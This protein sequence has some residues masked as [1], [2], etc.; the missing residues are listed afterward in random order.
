MPISI[1]FSFVFFHAVVKSS[2]KFD[3]I[4]LG[5]AKY[6]IYRGQKTQYFILYRDK[7]VSWG[8]LILGHLEVIQS[9]K[10]FNIKQLI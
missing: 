10:L 4:F 2:A 9:Q 1:I 8:R 3:F 7:N 6:L 5:Q